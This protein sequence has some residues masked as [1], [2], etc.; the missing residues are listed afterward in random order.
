MRIVLIHSGGLDSTVLL[1]KLRAEGHEVRC[2]GVDYGQRHRRELDAGQ[3]ICRDV[4]VEYRVA[5]LRGLRS[6]LAGSALTDSIPVPSGHYTDETMKATIVP[7]RNMIMLSVAIG[8]AVSLRYDAVAYAAHAG[9][10]TIYPDCRPVFVEA[11]RSVA[12]LCDWRPIELLAPFVGKSKAD[13]VR[14]G[15]ELGVPFERTWSCYRGG[16]LHCGTCGTCVERREAF[17]KAGIADRTVYR[18]Q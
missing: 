12:R 3:A 1:Y 13:I 15:A 9:D 17:Q 6:L 4:G 2:L 18:G 8:W 14:I 7:N 10:H 11:V 16:E 5:D